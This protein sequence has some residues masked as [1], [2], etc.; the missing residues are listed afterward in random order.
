M[1]SSGTVSSIPVRGVLLLAYLLLLLITLVAFISVFFHGF[2]VLG[3]KLY[4]SARKE[5]Q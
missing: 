4:Q 2:R 3:E 5:C 1:Y